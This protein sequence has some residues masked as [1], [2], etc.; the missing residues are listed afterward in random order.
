LQK[1]YYPIA[2]ILPTID[3]V[4]VAIAS[5]LVEEE[6]KK[7]IIM[8]FCLSPSGRASSLLVYRVSR[9]NCPF[10]FQSTASLA[11]AIETFSLVAVE[12]VAVSGSG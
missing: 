4:S 11:I 5:Y 10:D 7:G 1:R 9:T 3:A 8:C 6:E 2:F 12:I